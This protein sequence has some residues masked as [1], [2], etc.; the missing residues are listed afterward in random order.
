MRVVLA[1]LGAV[2]MVVGFPEDVEEAGELDGGGG[3][4]DVCLEGGVVEAAVDGDAGMPMRH[5]ADMNKF[6]KF[7]GRS[8]EVNE[9]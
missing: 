1:G 5:V 9:K 3:M 4:G 6:Y 7:M 8:A 2:L